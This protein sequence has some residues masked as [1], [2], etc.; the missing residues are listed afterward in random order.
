MKR[1]LHAHLKTDLAKKM[2]FITG[3]RQVGKTY[4]AKQLM[5]EYHSPIYLNYDNSDDAVVIDI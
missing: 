2:I 4:L 3:P 1:Y 5:R